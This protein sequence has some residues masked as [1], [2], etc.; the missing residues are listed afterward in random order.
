MVAG[1]L[2]ARSVNHGAKHISVYLAQAQRRG[3]IMLILARKPE[4]DAF[5][6]VIAHAFRATSLASHLSSHAR[7]A[8]SAAFRLF[9]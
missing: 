6:G 4:V 1:G 9:P 2:L 8:A 3:K 7:A 5:A